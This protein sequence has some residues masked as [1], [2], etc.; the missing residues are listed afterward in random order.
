MKQMKKL[1]I[2]VFFF[3]IALILVSCKQETVNYK[4][5]ESS[6]CKKLLLKAIECSSLISYYEHCPTCLGDSNDTYRPFFQ[7]HFPDSLIEYYTIVDSIEHMLINAEK[8]CA[9][10]WPQI[11]AR[12]QYLYIVT[13]Q[14]DKALDCLKKPI[15]FGPEIK[16]TNFKKMNQKVIEIIIQKKQH[17]LPDEVAANQIFTY[18][19][20]L[21]NLDKDPT[22]FHY[23]FILVDQYRIVDSHTQVQQLNRLIAKHKLDPQTVDKLKL[24]VGDAN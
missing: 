13:G 22:L 18:T 7:R 14:Y 11:N 24:G 20:S 12:L 9:D 1:F 15:D 8:S 5:P 3:S 4:S 10:L 6:H 16:H 19:D 21:Y 17:Q 23:Y 2:R